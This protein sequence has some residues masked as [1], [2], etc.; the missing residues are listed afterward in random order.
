AVRRLRSL[1][2]TLVN[3]ARFPLALLRYA[4][5]G[6]TDGWAHQALVQL[7]CASGGRFN[8]LLSGLIGLRARLLQIAD[9]V[10]VLGAMRGNTLSACLGELRQRGFT[11]FP[12]ALPM[13]MCERLMQFA[14]QTPAL[15][16]RMD[17]EPTGQ[18]PRMAMF[19]N[20]H[21]LAVRYDYPTESLLANAD[22]QE[23]L[24]D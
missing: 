9:P 7:F 8:D 10:G 19:D 22:V 12:G 16:R 14:L 24:S 3:L 2:R 11:T 6:R 4:R 5:S 13:D 21:P 23:L 15:V 18:P 17:H 1:A 20:G